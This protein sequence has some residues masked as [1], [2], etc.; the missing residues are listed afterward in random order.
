MRTSFLFIILLIVTNLLPAH[1]GI[2]NNVKVS[3]NRNHPILSLNKPVPFSKYL[4]GSSAGV[5]QNFPHSELN[6][7]PGDSINLTM[8]K[9]QKERIIAIGIIGTLSGT[10][11]GAMIGISRDHVLEGAAIG[12]SVG[13]FLGIYGSA[14]SAKQKGSFWVALL[15]NV[16]GG[17]A[18]YYLAPYSLGFSLILLPPTGTIVGFNMGK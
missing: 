3:V 9:E 8:S 5:S 10:L 6:L 11:L 14:K 4:R 15:G 12:G 2:R 17:V 1:S 18:G 16:A 7:Q 13:A